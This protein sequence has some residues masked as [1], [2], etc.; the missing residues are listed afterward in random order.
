[1]SEHKLRRSRRLPVQQSLRPINS[2]SAKISP[3]FS[4]VDLRLQWLIL[5]AIFGVQ[6][7]REGLSL[8]STNDLREPP[9]LF[10]FD[11]G[12]IELASLQH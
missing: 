4:Q 9:A 10:T 2:A 11:L 3:F 1:M 8:N 12:Y 7:L 5:D 6:L